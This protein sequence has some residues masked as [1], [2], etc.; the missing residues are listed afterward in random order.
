[1]AVLAELCLPF[2]KVGGVFAAL[3]GPRV[4]DELPRGMK[5]IETMGGAYG[6]DRGHCAALELRAK[7]HSDNSKEDIHT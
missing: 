6:E 1:M 4:K 5:A 2:V 7:V 3:K